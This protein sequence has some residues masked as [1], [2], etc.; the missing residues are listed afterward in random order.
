MGRGVLLASKLRGSDDL[1]REVARATLRGGVSE[2][3]PVPRSSQLLQLFPRYFPANG[4]VC[5]AP[6]T[7]FAP[8]MDLVE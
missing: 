8:S 4:L 1:S 3:V 2:C 7:L 5:P 6:R